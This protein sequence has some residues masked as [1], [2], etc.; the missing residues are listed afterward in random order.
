LSGRQQK[1]PFIRSIETG[2]L[3]KALLTLAGVWL[4]AVVVVVHEARGGGEAGEAA[5][6][7]VIAD[8]IAGTIANRRFGEG[9]EL[10]PHA[11]E[12]RTAIPSKRRVSPIHFI[13]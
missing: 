7:D 2:L 9:L 13:Y 5:R 10:E 3:L 11:R 1:A 4:L 6:G 8:T 12:E